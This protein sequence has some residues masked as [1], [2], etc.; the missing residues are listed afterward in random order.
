MKKPLAI[1][2]LLLLGIFMVSCSWADELPS[3]PKAGDRIVLTADDIEYAFRWCPPGEFMMGAPKSEWLDRPSSFWPY[4]ETPHNVK[5]TKGF[6]LLETEVTQAMWQSVVGE[7]IETKAKQGIDGRLYGK[8]ANYPM[9]YVNW[10]D[11]QNFCK[12]LS[13]KLGQHVQLPTEAQWEYAC[14]AGTTGAYAGT[15][16]EMGWYVDNSGWTTHPAGQKQPNPWG[17]YDMHGNVWEW[18]SDWYKKNYYSK[19]PASDPTGPDSGSLGVCRG[20]GWDDYAGN[21]RSAF[22][23]G[24][25][26]GVWNGDLGL[27]LLLVP[28]QE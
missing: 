14:R 28:S 20:G 17:L 21:C 22:R 18:C 11:C 25:S 4:N 3:N 15:L 1:L 26:P 7:S 27:R 6:W 13:E 24:Y 12:K 5:L 8:G 23:T 2:T 19:S 9:Y 16:D 10:Y